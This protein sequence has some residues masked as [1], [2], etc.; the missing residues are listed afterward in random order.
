[1][2]TPDNRVWYYQKTSLSVC[3]A[4]IICKNLGG[5]PVRP[6]SQADID[7]L[8]NL[9]NHNSFWIGAK[10]DPDNGWRARWTTTCPPDTMDYDQY[11][12]WWPNSDLSSTFSPLCGGAGQRAFYF[13]SSTQNFFPTNGYTSSLM[14]VCEKILSNSKVQLSCSVLLSNKV[15][16]FRLPRIPDSKW[17]YYNV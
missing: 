4:F 9:T 12:H 3:E 14:V 7:A 15:M 11:L 6:M 1:M 5:Y 16:S 17:I 8:N 10:G 13:N 2:I